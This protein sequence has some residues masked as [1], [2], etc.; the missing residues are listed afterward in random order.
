MHYD[1]LE[2][3][4]TLA[5]EGDHDRAYNLTMKHL[6][7]NP[8]HL[9]WS[10]LLIYLMLETDKPVIAYQLCKNLIAKHPRV[11]AVY[12]NMGTA[13]RDLWRDEESL[14][15]YKR[16]MSMTK[17][18]QQLSMFAINMSSMLVDL[19]RFDEAEK[20]CKQALEHNPE[21][22]KAQ[23]N[24]GFCQLARRN[25]SEGWGNYRKCLGHEWR[26]KHQYCDEPE[27][28]GRGTGNI[29]LYGEQG[30]GDQI[31]FASMLPDAMEWADKNDSRI[32]LDVSNRLSNLLRRSFPKLKVYGTQGNQEMYWDKEDRKV[33]YS[34]PIGQIAEYFRTKDEDFPGTPY[35]VPDEDRVLQWKALFESKGKPVI[36]IAWSG[37]IAKT[38]AKFRRVDL[39]RLRP[40][41]E[42]VDAHFVSLQYKPAGKEIAAFKEQYPH[43]DLVEYPHG[44][45]SNDYDDTV[46]MIAAMD[47]VVAMHTTAVHV[48]GG[49]GVPCWTLVPMNSQWRYG[50]GYEDFPWAKSLKLYRQTKRGEWTE[51]IK[52]LADELSALFPRVRKATKKAPRKR[53][54]RNNSPEIRANGVEHNRQAGA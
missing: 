20:F 41:L 39:E 51:V 32:I 46:A 33:D 10:L 28:D 31:S 44:T 24:L 47:H 3:A 34:L 27:W 21:S 40:V 54:L 22:P 45:L 12:T 4:R 6:K 53:K 49:L 18:P 50:Q 36:G 13:C 8:N 29:V 42:S 25:W 16:G 30:L 38:G 37:G 43:I 7:E 9:E 26:P 14:R 23:A 48:A 5:E 1:E 52:R 2:V 35:L 11:P 15:Y 17:D 19:G